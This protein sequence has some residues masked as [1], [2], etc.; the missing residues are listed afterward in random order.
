MRVCVAHHPAS[1]NFAAPGFELWFHQGD[2]LSPFAQDSQRGRQHE[3]QTDERYVDRDEIDRLRQTLEIA[4]IR[5]LEDN[6]T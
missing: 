2:D 6:D 1:S 3:P 5:P 4:N